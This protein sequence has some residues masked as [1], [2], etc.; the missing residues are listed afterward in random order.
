MVK[1]FSTYKELKGDIGCLGLSYS[2]IQEV[3]F[4]QL[5]LALGIRKVTSKYDVLMHATFDL[6]LKE[7]VKTRIY[8]SQS[9]PKRTKLLFAYD[10][11]KYVMKEIEKKYNLI[12][13]RIRQTQVDL[14]LKSVLMLRGEFQTRFRLLPC[15]TSATGS[16]GTTGNQYTSES[17]NPVSSPGSP[18]ISEKSVSSSGYASDNLIEENNPGVVY[19]YNPTYSNLRNPNLRHPAQPSY[20]YN[21]YTTLA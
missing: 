6:A 8:E 1:L 21:Y 2:R 13:N 18:G 9:V 15:C 4:S 5:R 12:D 10:E 14:I 17:T 20:H 7:K 3:A 11:L 16:N 19:E